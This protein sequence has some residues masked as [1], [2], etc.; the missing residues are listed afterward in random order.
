MHSKGVY[1]RDIKP[2]NIFLTQEGDIKLGD[3]GLATTDKFSDEI[4]VGSDRYMAPEQ[5]DPS[6]G[7]YQPAKADIWA[8]GICLL[9][10]LFARNPF[11]VPT[12][13]DPLFADFAFDRQSLFD[14]FP[15]MSEQ[16]YEVLNHCLTLDPSKR[17]LAG[18]KDAIMKV[19]SW[20]TDED[21]LDD[22]FC[23][24]D[25]DVVGVSANREPLR[26]PSIS[27]PQV[28][29]GGGF[30]WAQLLHTPQQPK[31]QLSV[32]PEPAV[33]TQSTYH[34]TATVPNSY[35]SGL[36]VSIESLP[37]KSKYKATNFFSN[38]RISIIPPPPKPFL[39]TSNLS[40]VTP[41][42]V[43]NASVPQIPINITKNSNTSYQSNSVSSSWADLWDEDMENEDL[44]TREKIKTLNGRTWSSESAKAPESKKYHDSDD[45]FGIS[46]LKV[47]D[48]LEWVTGGWDDPIA[49]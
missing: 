28:G 43:S 16:T 3:F 34:K 35:D 10:V 40:P 19:D 23:A 8:I 26:T 31:R 37:T 41:T 9:N 39:S 7:P 1:H 44:E 6:S 17:S 22:E 15:T 5:Y 4:S 12:T 20:T 45:I 42:F 30:P 24:D 36:G 2:E 32:I 13:E 14:I 29:L 49:L 46:Q 18:L 47:D 21:I 11:T 33:P 27:S 25:R 48:D 38:S